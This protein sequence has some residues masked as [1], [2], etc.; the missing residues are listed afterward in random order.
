MIIP[1]KGDGKIPVRSLF[2]I[3]PKV[4]NYSD[5]LGTKPSGYQ[6]TSVLLI[7]QILEQVCDLTEKLVEKHALISHPEVTTKIL[8]EVGI[9]DINHIPDILLEWVPCHHPYIRGD[10]TD[11]F[12]LIES[13]PTDTYLLYRRFN[14]IREYV[15]PSMDSYI[16][17]KHECL[18]ARAMDI[19][20]ISS[21]SPVAWVYSWPIIS[22]Q[23][24]LLAEAIDKWEMMS[25]MPSKF[26]A[27][28]EAKPK[29]SE[30]K[31]IPYWARLV[32]RT[33]LQAT[34]VQTGSMSKA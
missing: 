21:T 24:D 10:Q 1:Y 15:N 32:R 30:S 26:E 18:Q 11:R 23:F 3:L 17:F 6:A 9:T 29:V 31:P 27:S 34:A 5:R 28:K 25:L 12:E 16:A 8:R 19:F 20:T 33:I 2:T 22:Y 4:L 13:S 14:A 7:K